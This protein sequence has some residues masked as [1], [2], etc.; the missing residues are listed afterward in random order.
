MTGRIFI[1]TSAIKLRKFRRCSLVHA[2][3]FAALGRVTIADTSTLLPTPSVRCGSVFDLPRNLNTFQKVKRFR[4]E[5]DLPGGSFAGSGSILRIPVRS[6]RL[7]SRNIANSSVARHSSSS[8]LGV[9]PG[10]TISSSLRSGGWSR[11]TG[12]AHGGAIPAWS[13]APDV[14]RGEAHQARASAGV[15]RT[16]K[17]RAE[18][19]TSR[20]CRDANPPTVQR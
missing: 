2:A 5:L 11:G 4:G 6:A 15:P 18:D 16:K 14:R 20:P 7:P 1:R 8:R 3:P 13:D 9:N 17:R 19:R 12:S 10:N